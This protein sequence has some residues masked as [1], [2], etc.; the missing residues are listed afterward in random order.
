MTWPKYLMLLWQKSRFGLFVIEVW[1]SQLSLFYTSFGVG[2]FVL[3]I[4]FHG[5]SLLLFALACTHNFKSVCYFSCVVKREFLVLH[6]ISF[7]VGFFY[8]F[9][10]TLLVPIHLSVDAILKLTRKFFCSRNVWLFTFSNQHHPTMDCFNY[11]L[12]YLGN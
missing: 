7:I 5:N 8:S 10:S 9:V 3:C 4:S 11:L 6:F 1:W 2:L 12:P